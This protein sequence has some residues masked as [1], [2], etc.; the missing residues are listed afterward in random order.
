[1]LNLHVALNVL[2]RTFESSN[3]FESGELDKKADD[4]GRQLDSFRLRKKGGQEKKCKRGAAGYQTFK[5]DY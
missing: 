5:S 3:F 2:F 4:K 1:M